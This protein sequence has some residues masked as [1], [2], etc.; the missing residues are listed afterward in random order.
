MIAALVVAGGITNS[1]PRSQAVAPSSDPSGSTNARQELD[2]Q[3]PAFG[4]G[5]INLKDY[6]G[7]VVIVDFWASW[8][9]PCLAKLPE[10]KALHQAYHKDGLEIIGVSLDFSEKELENYLAGNP[11]PWKQIIFPNSRDQGWKNPIARRFGV[12]SIPRLVVVD[13]QGKLLVDDPFGP[14]LEDSIAAELGVPGGQTKGLVQSNPNS[15]ARRA[16]AWPFLAV[17]QGVFLA[18]LWLIL[19]TFPLFSVI[20]ALLERKL[21]RS[22]SARAAA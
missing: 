12:N 5:E 2:I 8:C 11:L 14:E 6:R 3:G 20:G 9:G 16:L 7:K 1:L 22:R 21:S 18:P 15:F 19:V 10:L 17:T 4:G 13:K